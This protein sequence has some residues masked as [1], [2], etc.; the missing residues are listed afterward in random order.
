MKTAI[1]N[2]GLE[3]REQG[4]GARNRG[5]GIAACLAAAVVSVP[6]GQT[7]V[8][9]LVVVRAAR[10]ID[11]R[12]GP[13]VQPAVIVVRGDKIDAVGPNLP[14]PSGA[15]VIDLGGA[16]IVPG[17]IDLHTHLTSTGVHWEDELVKTTPGQAALS[18]A[19][20]ARITLEAGFTTVRDMGP[21]W[22]F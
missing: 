5:L 21:T 2:R 10:I 14:V 8:D 11:G 13:V 3:G 17:L 16:T 9:T 6:A 4:P 22:P 20:N 1:R 15:R 18:G 19:H 12:G 7:K